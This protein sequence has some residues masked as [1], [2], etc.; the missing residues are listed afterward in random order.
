MS[1]ASMQ[2]LNLGPA[3]S[4]APVIDKFAIVP[5]MACVY[6]TIITPLV[7]FHFDFHANVQNAEPGLVNRLFWPTMSAVSIAL[8][9]SN[10]SRL[11]K[12][13]LPPN[14]I[15]LLPYVAFAGA[16][17]LWA[18]RPEFSLIRFLQQAMVL[19]SIIMPAMLAA[20][21]V[22]M[23][24]GLFLCFALGA[25]LNILF[26]FDNPVSLVNKESGGFP[27]YM[28][29][30]NYLGEFST[31][32]LLLAVHE[33]F[34][35]GLRRAFGAIIV[36]IAT[37]LLFMANSKTAI[38]LAF[39]VP[40]LA[41]LTLIVRKLTRIS[42]AIILLSIPLCYLV[43]SSVSG[44]TMNRLSYMLYGDSSFTG[45]TVIWNFAD[46]EIAHKPF[47]GWGYQSFWLVGS[48]AVSVVEAPGFVKSMPNAHNGYKDTLLEMGYIGYT[49]LL[50]FIMAT[51]HA[52]GRVADRAPAR[53]WLVLSLGLY[54]I[55][56]NFLE[57]FWMRG[58]EFMWVMFVILTAEIARCWQH[59]P[60]TKGG[61][62]RQE[63]AVSALHEARGN[64]PRR[65]IR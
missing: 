36:V 35:P 43:L 42:P 49:L 4:S 2:S 59:F 25:I 29:G 57:S 56:Y 19:V 22:D 52:I 47:A 63:R 60:M 11:R 34:Y 27:G 45:R 61:A 44:F 64:L 1:K 14:I 13:T 55:I 23:M 17:V 33:A 37:C 8:V 9:V 12:L 30:K 32:A 39:F 38:G 41:G 50:T 5:I 6:A 28:G 65:Q 16:S 62:R 26:I 10:C 46:Y 15:C 40:L 20:R 54:F 24:R 7:D 31:V 48:D 58:H 18:F 51:L 21:T 53:A 3:R